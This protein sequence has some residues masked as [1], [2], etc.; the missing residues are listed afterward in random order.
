[1]TK[2]IRVSGCEQ[3][4]HGEGAVI[5]RLGIEAFMALK[6]TQSVTIT[7]CARTGDDRKFILKTDG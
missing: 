1:M 7:E 2:L 6:P 5:A 4:I 3:T